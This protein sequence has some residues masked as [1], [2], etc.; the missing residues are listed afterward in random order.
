MLEAQGQ[1][2]PCLVTPED[3]RQQPIGLG[4]A[5]PGIGRPILSLDLL[6]VAVALRHGARLIS[7]DTFSQPSLP[8]RGAEKRRPQ[9]SSLP[10]IPILRRFF[11][12]GL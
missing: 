9:A 10:W 11:S 2:L 6:V 4:Q 5:C 8:L 7:F 1:S 3:L 12:P